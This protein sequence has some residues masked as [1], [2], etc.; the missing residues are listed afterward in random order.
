MYV[1]VCVSLYAC[2]VHGNVQC[3]RVR[4]CDNPSNLS[5]YNPKYVCP[6]NR[7]TRIICRYG[8]PAK[9]LM[10]LWEGVAVAGA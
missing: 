4:V 5:P 3:V 7:I 10:E 6:K 2:M 9:R 8:L 1:C